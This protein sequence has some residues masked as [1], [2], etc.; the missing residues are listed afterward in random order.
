MFLFVQHL[1]DVILRSY[2]KLE[3]TWVCNKFELLF[4][5][6][7]CTYLFLQLLLKS[8]CSEFKLLPEK[9]LPISFAETFKDAIIRRGIIKSRWGSGQRTRRRIYLR[10]SS[11]IL[12]PS[13]LNVYLDPSTGELPGGLSQPS[14]LCSV[15]LT[16]CILYIYMIF[17]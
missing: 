6:L 9:R 7:Y 3:L 1:L 5:I 15:R 2:K 12:Y 8:T 17:I 14:S 13:S 16:K 10:M 11:W 4:V